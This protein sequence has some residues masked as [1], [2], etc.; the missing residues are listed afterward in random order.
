MYDNFRKYLHFVERFYK[1]LTNLIRLIFKG[2]RLFLGK[3]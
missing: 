3:N 2:I 1:K